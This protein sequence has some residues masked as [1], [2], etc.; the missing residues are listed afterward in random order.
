MKSTSE[1]SRLRKENDQ[2][3][4]SLKGLQSNY[5][6]GFNDG[7]KQASVAAGRIIDILTDKIRVQN[8]EI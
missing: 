5:L 8:E 1:L 3:R 6:D 2:L 7:Y 4:S